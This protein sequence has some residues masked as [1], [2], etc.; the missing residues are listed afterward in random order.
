MKILPM[1]KRT[2]CRPFEHNFIFYSEYSIY[3]TNEQFQILKQEPLD[4]FSFIL[5][6][7][8]Q[9]YQYIT[10]YHKNRYYGQVLNNLYEFS[11]NTVTFLGQI[12]NFIINNLNDQIYHATTLNNNIIVYNNQ[13]FFKYDF[14]SKSFIFMYKSSIQF[15]YILGQNK[16]IAY[17]NI[18]IVELNLEEAPQDLQLTNPPLNFLHFNSG[19]VYLQNKNLFFILEVDI[20]TFFQG[21][22]PNNFIFQNN[23]KPCCFGI[24]CPSIHDY[25]KLNFRG[26]VLKISRARGK[27]DKEMYK[28]QQE[29]QW[30]GQNE[31]LPEA[32][33]LD[34]N[35][36]QIKLIN[37]FQKD[38]FTLSQDRVIKILTYPYKISEQL[39]SLLHNSTLSINEQQKSNRGRKHKTDVSQ[40]QLKLDANGNPR[41]RG[42]PPLIKK[43]L[44]KSFVVIEAD[45]SEK[46]K[47]KRKGKDSLSKH[48]FN[49]V[50][51][52]ELE[53]LELSATE[54]VQK[55]DKDEIISQLQSEIE[56]LRGQVQ[57]L[58]QT[59]SVVSSQNLKK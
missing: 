9:S 37:G 23:L 2:F 28:F 21:K 31:F 59:L 48:S 46:G 42:R 27:R 19:L 4:D 29:T 24:L 47:K 52:L 58:T 10:F 32:K 22:M 7:D 55:L 17:N 49:Q 3:T 39:L 26:W 11:V 15:T 44:L 43:E 34:I 25:C 53:D 14:Q 51:Q 35:F 16:A 56:Q 1:E 20:L 38:N 40:I 41:K 54:P 50:D 13:E 12:P 30:V 18:G 36:D 6:K 5:D 8:A 33:N 57:Q 45:N